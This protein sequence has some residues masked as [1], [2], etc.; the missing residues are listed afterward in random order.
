[1]H[2]SFL[3]GLAIMCFATVHGDIYFCHIMNNWVS[4]PR[5]KGYMPASGHWRFRWTPDLERPTTNT[6]IQSNIA[7]VSDKN[8]ELDF[9]EVKD[10][11]NLNGAGI[12]IDGGGWTIGIRMEYTRR[13]F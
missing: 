11:A 12:M 2:E 4:P 6:R 7:Q 13:F 1:M 10:L 9:L 5:V 8:N 3:G